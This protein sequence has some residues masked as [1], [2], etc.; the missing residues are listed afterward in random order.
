VYNTVA[1][2]VVPYLAKP[3][4]IVKPYVKAADDLGDKILSKL[5]ERFPAV[6]TPTGDLVNGV[7]AIVSLP[8][9]V[10][11]AGRDHLLTTYNAEYKKCGNNNSVTTLSKATVTTALIITTESLTAISNFVG[12]KKE[13][14]KQSV[15]ERANN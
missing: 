10:G 2:P 3:F 7:F 15:N 1:A 4:E 13:D 11:S 9:R 12:S 14:V 5:D 6:K 8:I